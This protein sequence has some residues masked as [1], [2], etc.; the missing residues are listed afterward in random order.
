[1][2]DAPTPARSVSPS[3]PPGSARLGVPFA[4]R[5]VLLGAASVAAAA[6]APGLGG[7]RAAHAEAAPVVRKPGTPGLLTGDA[8]IAAAVQRWRALVTGGDAVDPAQ[9]DTAAA[10]KRLDGQVEGFRSALVTSPDRTY[11]WPDQTGTDDVT[12]AASA[13]RLATMAT[14]YATKGSRFAGDAELASLVAEALAWLHD[15]RY[16]PGMTETGNWWN[17]EIGTRHAFWMP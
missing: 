16:H 13:Q 1:M 5:T 4:R 15:Q 11:L 6:A 2:S 3:L 7:T 12:T 9:T 10:L 14:A 8:D 17:W